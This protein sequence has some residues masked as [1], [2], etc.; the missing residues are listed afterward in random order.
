MKLHSC[1]IFPILRVATRYQLDSEKLFSIILDFLSHRREEILNTQLSRWFN[2]FDVDIKRELKPILYELI[3][4][5]N[6]TDNVDNFFIKNNRF[7]IKDHVN[8][9]NEW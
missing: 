3:S 5:L 1:N 2:P 7:Y 8:E 4:E 6:Y 9:S